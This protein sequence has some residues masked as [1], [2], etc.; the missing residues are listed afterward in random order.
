[1]PDDTIVEL[2]A[3]ETL[4][5][6]ARPMVEVDVWTADGV[7]G[8]GSSPC[9]TSVGSHEAFLLRDGGK[10]YGGLGVQ[11]AVRNVREVIAPALTGRSVANQ[12][13][14]DSMLI[15]LDGM[16]NKSRL[17]ANAIYSVSIAVARAAAATLHVPLYR[18]LGGPA[19]CGL[20]VPMFN[21]INGGHYAGVDMAIQEFQVIPATARCY[22]EALQMGVEIYAALRE[23]IQRRYGKDRLFLGRSAGY[24]APAGEPAEV[25]EILLAAADAAGYGGQCRLGLDCAASEFYDSATGRYQFG[26]KAMDREELIDLLAGLAKAYELFMIEDPLDEDDFEGFAAIT[27]RVP[28][29]IVGDDLFVTNLE[30]IKHGIALGAANAM[31]LKP[32]MV[33]TISEA[34]LAA[35]YAQ[36]HGYLVIGSGRAGGTVDDPITDI[37][38][39]VGAPLVKLGA[40]RSGERLAKHNAILRIEEELGAAARFAGP[41]I[42]ARTCAHIEEVR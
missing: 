10:R 6:E 34:L 30:R 33:G 26:R 14:I 32:N 5:S 16:P 20:P 17:G 7:L 35:R 39:A 15:E 13:Q 21:M 3:R 8:R 1:M 37:A 24:G 11:H 2:K 22:A 31:I 9:G 38:V 27:R 28:A 19:P 29:I 36:S 4:D 42:F 12:Q 23:I 41:E 25:L 18:Y 40:P